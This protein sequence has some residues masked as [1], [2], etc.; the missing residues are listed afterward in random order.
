M[1]YG[2]KLT[3]ENCSS[4]NS[5]VNTKSAFLSDL[6]TT[7]GFVN[8][9]LTIEHWFYKLHKKISF[10]EIYE[11]FLNKIVQ[12]VKKFENNKIYLQNNRVLQYVYAV[13][14][15]K[16]YNLKYNFDT[17]SIE[18][19]ITG[20]FTRVEN[21]IE[22][23]KKALREANI[24]EYEKKYEATT[25]AIVTS[26][27]N[28]IK[29]DI[30]PA[31]DESIK[32]LNDNINVL[33]NEVIDN[34]KNVKSEINSLEKLKSKLESQL[35]L[36]SIL[37]VL[38]VVGAGLAVFGVY[39]AAAG[40]AITIVSGVATSFIPDED[41][42]ISTELPSSVRQSITKISDH[43]KNNGLIFDKKLQSLKQDLDNSLKKLNSNE[44]QMIQNLTAHVQHKINKINSQI[45]V[46][47]VGAV[48]SLEKE[49]INSVTKEIQTINTEKKK[50]QKDYDD[51]VRKA[52][53]LDDATLSK[54]HDMSIEIKRLS[55]KPDE[56]SKN[57][58]TRLK[59]E[60]ENKINEITQ[61]NNEA[62]TITNNQKSLKSQANEFSKERK[63]LLK[64]YAKEIESGASYDPESVDKKAELLKKMNGISAKEETVLKTLKDEKKI[65]YDNY[66]KALNNAQNVI[67]MSEAVFNVYSQVSNGKKK[68]DKVKIQLENANKKIK[69]LERYRISI[70]E[71]LIPLFQQ[72]ESISTGSRKNLNEKSHVTLD[73]TKWK[74][75]NT[76]TG[77]QNQVRDMTNGFKAQGQFKNCID[78]VDYGIQ[79]MIQ[80]YDR[81]QNEK[82]RKQLANYIAEK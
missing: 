81:I 38:Q 74:L 6:Y 4:H 17:L 10:I 79:T 35:V 75:R 33:V 78:K 48:T 36:K 26:A 23:Y 80:M 56:I 55:A 46:L 54:L 5:T 61:L 60:Q 19:D 64:D 34:Q 22:E 44:L 65:K 2:Y 13:T 69:D 49:F 51:V 43:A 58:I 32:N 25:E 59:K 72:L 7:S 11:T 67:G 21:H 73:I 53:N 40:A 52:V 77:I 20:Y 1:I 76:I 47:E 41:D 30:Q 70:Y 24:N 63:K 12:H 27:I 28:V 71:T 8:E 31:I 50:L 39:G 18:L 3:H 29:N 68:I 66:A 37:S 14:A 42:V 9:L 15:S 16:L 45:K 82:E 62:E 57:E